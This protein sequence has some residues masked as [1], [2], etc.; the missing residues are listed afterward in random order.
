V[1]LHPEYLEKQQLPPS[2]KGRKIW[3][4]RFEQINNFEKYLCEN[5]IVVLK[6]FL[7]VSKQEQRQRL[8]KRID[9]S[10]KELEVFDCGHEQSPAMG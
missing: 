5:G 1:R 7:N 8:L 6:I 2:V 9:E 10:G 4:R 3:R